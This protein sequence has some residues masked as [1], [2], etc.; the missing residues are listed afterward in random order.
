M[1]METQSNRRRQLSLLAAIATM[2]LLAGF[3]AAYLRAEEAARFPK[4][5]FSEMEK[6][7]EI[8]KYEYG[9][10]A[11]NHLLTIWI[12]PKVE[13][14]PKTFAMQFLDKDGVLVDPYDPRYG[15]GISLD[16]V[17]PVGQVQKAT[18]YTPKEKAM[19]RVVSAKV[20]R[21]KG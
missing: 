2:V 16:Y 12:K 11:T 4:P 14:R 3:K 10:P 19:E 5:D 1:K 9:D 8:V 18:C 13:D 6:W 17:V 7:Y 21:I 15:F 20:V